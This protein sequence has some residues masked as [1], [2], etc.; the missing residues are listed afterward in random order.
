MASE[1]ASSKPI[2][3]TSWWSARRCRLAESLLPSSS[4]QRENWDRP[5]TS[6]A[7]GQ[8]KCN[9]LPVANTAGG[10]AACAA[11]QIDTLAHQIFDLAL[12]GY[13]STSMCALSSIQSIAF[14]PC[15]PTQIAL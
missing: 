4:G 14:R 2:C 15:T 11:R 9:K 1:A 3:I 12:P 13:G 7:T 5:R 10:A 8:G 6:T